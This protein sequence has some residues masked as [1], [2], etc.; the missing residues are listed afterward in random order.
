[1]MRVLIGLCMVAVMTAGIGRDQGNALVRHDG[2]I[3][4]VAAGLSRGTSSMG[5]SDSALSVPYPPSTPFRRLHRGRHLLTEGLGE[6]PLFA[7]EFKVERISPWSCVVRPC[8]VQPF[9]H[10]PPTLAELPRVFGIQGPTRRLSDLPPSHPSCGIGV[11][12]FI[13]RKMTK[14]KNQS[15]RAP[16]ASGRQEATCAIFTHEEGR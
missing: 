9:A 6:I 2:S 12:A 16:P 7:L 4:S 8:C 15:A 13:A 1:M 3:H 10:G 11:S 14:G 5:E